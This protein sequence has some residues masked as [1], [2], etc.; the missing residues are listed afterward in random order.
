MGIVNENMCTNSPYDKPQIKLLL[1]LATL[2]KT[3]ALDAPD[4][5]LA[6]GIVGQIDVPDARVLQQTLADHEACP[7][8]DGVAGDT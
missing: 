7:R 6:E 4:S 1:I 5:D 2:H 3:E 8:V